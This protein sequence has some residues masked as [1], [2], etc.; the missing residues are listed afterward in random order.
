[1]ECWPNTRP[2]GRTLSSLPGRMAPKARSTI[3]TIPIRYSR[4]SARC[5]PRNS[6]T[7]SPSSGVKHQEFLGY[8]DSGMMGTEPNNNPDS[9]W[10]ADLM[11]ATGR[12]ISMIRTY[13]PDVMTIYDP[14]GGYGH[15]DHI[16]VHRIGIAAFF[17]SLDQGRFPLAEGEELW[18]P[19]KLYWN[20]WPRSR[21]QVFAKHRLAAG[22]I[23][24]E[25]YKGYQK[26]GIPDEEITTTVDISDYLAT[27]LAALK[28][29]RTQIPD[30]WFMFQVPEDARPA[31]FGTETF[32]RVFSRV[33][34]PARESD[35]F[36]GLR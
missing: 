27:K 4:S 34:A 32:Q 2:Q 17:G 29:H 36:E 21:L 12:L 23:T 33:D 20:V 13:Q 35:L 5:E 31:V 14:F 28:A 22:T 16:Q 24:E 26:A 6:R 9:F 25:E 1:M 10:Q 30:D 11:E 15:P 18:T 19:Y 8:R 3:T 7:L